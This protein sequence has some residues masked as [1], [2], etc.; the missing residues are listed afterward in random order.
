MI[1]NSFPRLL[2]KIPTTQL[3][4]NL[5]IVSELAFWLKML[6]NADTS[7]KVIQLLFFHKC[8]RQGYLPFIFNK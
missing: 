7:K 2:V 8:D 4:S 5:E 6:F 1:H 3:S